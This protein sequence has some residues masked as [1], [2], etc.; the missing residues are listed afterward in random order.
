MPMLRR[1]TMFCLA[2]A[3]TGCV[4][5]GA[6]NTL[7]DQNRDLKA[8]LDQANEGRSDLDKQNTDLEATA[9]DLTNEDTV[10]TGQ[11]A[12][13]E[14]R[15]AA[16]VA[17][18]RERKAEYGALAADLSGEIEAGRIKIGQYRNMLT[19]EVGD[20]IL[21]ES[22]KADLNDNGKALLLKVGK[23]FSKSDK[24]VRVVGNTDDVPMAAGAGYD[25]N[26]E[27]ST[28]RAVTVVRF[29]EHQAGLD[30]ARLM[31][32][33]RGKWMPVA[34]NDTPENRQKN[35]RI[36]ISLIDRGLVDGIGFKP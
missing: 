17:R 20:Q 9:A 11:K 8:Q 31:A 2:G 30:P 16:L 35:R 10:L 13:L 21:F 24:V 4:S 5:Q 22:A 12:K 7:R 28:A 19:V 36:E 25:N 14:A 26:W 33:G 32:A 27:L 23:D 29:L 3:L 1:L 6:Y 15:N 34:P 18:G